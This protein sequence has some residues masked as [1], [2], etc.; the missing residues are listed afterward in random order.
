MNAY[1]IKP[2]DKLPPRSSTGNATYPFEAMAPGQMFFVPAEND[3]D[4]VSKRLST[5]ASNAGKRL[6][7]K[8]TVR[9]ESRDG[10]KG[11]AC[12]C[13]NPE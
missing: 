9:A 4:Q 12:Y 1:T 3:K 6:G 7:K 5:A 2:F 8:F 10:V 13:V 11:A